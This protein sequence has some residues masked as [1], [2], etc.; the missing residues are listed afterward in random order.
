MK[1]N[2]LDDLADNARERLI[3]S[4]SHTMA[5]TR[6]RCDF[7]PA[8]DF[9]RLLQ[10]IFW[11]SLSRDE[12]RLCRFRVAYSPE[13]CDSNVTVVFEPISFERNTLRRLAHVAFAAESEIAVTSLRNQLQIVGLCKSFDDSFAISR[14]TPKRLSATF[15]KPEPQSASSSF[16]SDAMP[17][18]ALRIA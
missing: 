5:T 18:I 15:P 6:S 4:L 2:S 1:V 7:L 3:V 12:A 16:R 9:F 11:A 17:R 8:M 13:L 14:S 10:E